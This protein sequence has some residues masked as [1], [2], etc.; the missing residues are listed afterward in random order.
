MKYIALLRGINVGGNRKVEMKKLKA[1]LESMGYTDVSTYLNSG[2]AR[3]ESNLAQE[4]ILQAI[5]KAF[6]DEFGYEIPILIK[7]QEEIEAI[8]AAIPE[9]WQNNKE[10]KTDVA[11]LFPE[12]DSEKTIDELPL[13]REYVDFI[14]I[15]GAII[16]HIMK[17]DYNKS[18][19][20]K[21]VGRKLYQLM[22]VRNV[23]TARFLGDYKP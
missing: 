15:K 6:T 16:W 8:V 2:N 23:N 9:E 17:K 20:N 18:Q 19:L 21:L 5:S 14:Y 3:F 7:T 13:K 12:I 10:E 1:M 22:T 11:F 4:E